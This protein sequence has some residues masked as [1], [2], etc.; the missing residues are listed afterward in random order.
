[1][2][3]QS[4]IKLITNREKELEEKVDAILGTK[5]LN[6]LVTDIHKLVAVRELIE[7]LEIEHSR[8]SP[9]SKAKMESR[10]LQLRLEKRNNAKRAAEMYGYSSDFY[11]MYKTEF[12]ELLNILQD[13]R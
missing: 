8:D 7:I 1:M 2:T 11:I 4:M 10:F 6:E 5:G 9:L 13:C 12:G 3:K